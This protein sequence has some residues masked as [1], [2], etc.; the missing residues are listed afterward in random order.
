[1]LCCSISGAAH[2]SFPGPWGHPGG[3]MGRAKGL[4]PE[5]RGGVA[6]SPSSLPDP[7]QREEKLS[8]SARC[9]RSAGAR[10]GFGVSRGSQQ[11]HRWSNM[12]HSSNVI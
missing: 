6:P 11:P 1:M 4:S 8:S 12:V 2:Q 5:S 9:G 10:G 7:L 3:S